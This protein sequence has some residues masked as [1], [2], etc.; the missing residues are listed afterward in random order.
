VLGAVQAL[1]PQALAVTHVY[2]VSWLGQRVTPFS[3]PEARAVAHVAD[4][5]EP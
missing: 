1:V 4:A 3:Q 2:Q 5:A